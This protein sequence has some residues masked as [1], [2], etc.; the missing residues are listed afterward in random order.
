MLTRKRKI[1][2]RRLKAYVFGMCM[3]NSKAIIR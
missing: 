3:L 2:I 1:A